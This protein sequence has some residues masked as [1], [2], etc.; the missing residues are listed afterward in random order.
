MKLTVFHDGHFWVGVVE[1]KEDCG[2]LRAAKLIFGSEPSDQEVLEFVQHRLHE[3]ASRLSRPVETPVSEER[4]KNP[5]RLARE[6]ARELHMKGISSY[7]Q[8]ALKLEHETRKKERQVFS[9][10]QKEEMLER[11]RE[12]RLQKAKAKHRGK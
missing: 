12:I 9:R 10:Q 5:K 11:K 8:E 1:E 2:K 6:A 3:V 7:A 4:R